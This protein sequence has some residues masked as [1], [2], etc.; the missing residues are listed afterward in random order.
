MYGNYWSST[1]YESDSGRAH[2]LFFGSGI[3]FWS[4]GNHQGLSVRPVR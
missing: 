3:V 1:L 2:Y 4:E